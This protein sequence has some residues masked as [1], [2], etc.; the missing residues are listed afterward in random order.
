VEADDLSYQPAERLTHRPRSSSRRTKDRQPRS[1]FLHA[2]KSW[3]PTFVGRTGGAA[4]RRSFRRSI[5]VTYATPAG[6]EKQ[7]TSNE[8]HG[9]L[10]GQ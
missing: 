3:I 10:L 6:V 9:G 5:S 8:F 4:V 7:N 2:A 1:S